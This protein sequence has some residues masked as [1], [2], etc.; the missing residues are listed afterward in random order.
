MG[1]LSKYDVLNLLSKKMPFFAA[2]Q[3]LKSPHPSFGGK[4]PSDLI[5]GG[6]SKLVYS[7][8]KLDIESKNKNG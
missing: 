5:K 1:N 4:S 8:L 2:T 7:Q 6:E 3:W